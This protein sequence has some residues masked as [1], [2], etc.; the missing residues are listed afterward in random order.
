MNRRSFLA[1]LPAASTLAATER[2]NVIVMVADDLNTA[3]GCYGNTVVKTPNLD[4]FAARAVRFDRAYCQFP[5]C[6][7]S[8]SSFLS[9]RRPETTRVWTND[10]PTREYMRD[11]V[12]LP[13]FFRQRGYFSAQVG[14]IYQK[15]DPRSW[16]FAL[17]ESGKRPPAEEI[18]ERHG[19][20]EPLNCTM[21]WAKLKTP[22][23]KTPDGIVAR[24]AAELMRKAVKE[25]RSFFMGIG[26]RRPH[27]PYAVPVKYFDLYTPSRIPLP[28]VPPGHEKTLLPASKFELDNR[29]RLTSE[30]TQQYL[31]AYYACNSFVDAQV[32]HVLQA[33]HELDLWRNT[34][35]VFLGDQGYHNGEHGMWHKMTLF[36]Q[37]TRVPLLVYAPLRK[38]MGGV[39]RGLV[40]FV[41]IYP[42]LAEICGFPAPSG[43]EGISLAPWLDNPSRPAKRAAFSMVGRRVDRPMNNEITYL[44]K[45]VRTE[46][47]RYTE[48]DEGRRGVELYD[49]QND[50]RELHNIAADPKYKLAVT[51][52]HQLLRRRADSAV[53]N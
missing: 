22:D 32:G 41:D 4:R 23:E 46:R 26:F 51:E 20:P 12:M 11:V 47:W 8:R 43:L 2:M 5:L 24:K 27:A 44:G 38:G 37:S 1:S 21:E 36:E 50:P 10:T 34:A 6:N 17:E 49:E 16:D 15:P 19:M 7:P 52:L 29:V 28:Q 18:L 31:A 53:G 30:Q 45:S 39:C 42:T 48:W 9:G 13:E 3:I 40:E 33:V 35:I 25:K 14:K